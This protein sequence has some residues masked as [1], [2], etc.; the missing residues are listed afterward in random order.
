MLFY[1]PL[2]NLIETRTAIKN[3]FPHL[4]ERT[5]NKSKNNIHQ[6]PHFMNAQSKSETYKIKVGLKHRDFQFT[7]FVIFFLCSLFFSTNRSHERINTRRFG[8]FVVLLKYVFSIFDLCECKR[9]DTRE[10]VYKGRCVF[11]FRRFRM[12]FQFCV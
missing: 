11:S 7:T 12:L 5:R 1:T 4:S 9:A 2:Y 6:K 3:A 10:N 8:F